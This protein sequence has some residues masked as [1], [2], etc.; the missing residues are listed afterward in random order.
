LPRV[1]QLSVA[2]Q[3]FELRQP[4][5]ITGDFKFR[6]CSLQFRCF[7]DIVLDTEQTVDMV[8]S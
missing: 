6:P 1:T 4:G 8:E 7:V 5:F 3:G 2:E